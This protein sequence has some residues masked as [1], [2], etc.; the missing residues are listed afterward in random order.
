MN[1]YNLLRDWYNFKFANPS[2]AKA[3]HSDMY[4]YLID[5]WNRLGQKHE[6]GLPTSVTMESLGIGSYNTY[7]KTLNDLIDFGFITIISESKNQ[8]QSKIIALS[9]NDKATDKALDEANNK[10]TDKATDTIY[11]QENNR[12][13]EQ[14]INFEALLQYLN[15]TFGRQFKIVN[16]KVR[17]KYKALLKNGY[18]TNDIF[19]TINNCLNNKFHKDTNYQYCTPEYFSRAEIID[20][21][22]S[23]STQEPAFRMSHPTIID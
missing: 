4:C 20:K 13:I 18:T 19:A 17:K 11:K 7:K 15:S 6:F 21:Y 9:K 23:V 10:A 12:T 8:H 1:G 14:P 3:N 5:R 16:D 2:K 22:G